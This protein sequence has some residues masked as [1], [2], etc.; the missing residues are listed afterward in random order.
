[1]LPLIVPTVNLNGSSEHDLIDQLT[2]IMTALSVAERAMAKATPHGRDYACSALTGERLDA[3]A[4]DAFNERRRALLS[5]HSDF[6]ALAL[7]I[8][9]QGR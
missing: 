3:R 1:M 8:Q 5:M 4:R 2:E 7:D 6:L 9:K